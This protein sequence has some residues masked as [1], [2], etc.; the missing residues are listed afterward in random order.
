MPKIF[1]LIVLYF[2]GKVEISQLYCL[3]C[4]GYKPISFSIVVQVIRI[5]QVYFQLCNPFLRAVALKLIKEVNK[6][7]FRIYNW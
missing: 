5:A 2:N 3:Q 4:V 1:S 7:V 6:G